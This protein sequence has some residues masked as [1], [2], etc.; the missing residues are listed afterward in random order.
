MVVIGIYGK[1]GTGKD[2]ICNHYIMPFIQKKLGQNCLH[3]SFADQIK[4]NV[5]TKDSIPYCDVFDQKTS[6]T[7]TLLQKEGT[8]LGRKLHGEDIW[9]KY[10]ANWVHMFT[11]RGMENVVATDVRH[12]NEAEFI[13]KN[14]S[15]ILIKVHA[16]QRN[17]ERLQKESNGDSAVYH[18]IKEHPSEC[19][20]DDVDDTF[21]D[22]VVHNDRGNPFLD[23]DIQSLYEILSKT[24]DETH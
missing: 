8:E 1:M 24:R 9:I 19:D 6:K 22:V 12:K 15:G 3:L 4:V 14:M 17:E 2:Y 11:N 7:R 13:R 18:K 10:W 5:M 23:N 16:P 21:F 20:L